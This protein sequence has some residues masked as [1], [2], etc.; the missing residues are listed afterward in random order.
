MGEGKGIDSSNEKQQNLTKAGE[1]KTLKHVT[2][3]E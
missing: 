2:S 3:V 1:D